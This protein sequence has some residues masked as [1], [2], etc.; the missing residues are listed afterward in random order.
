MTGR[1]QRSWGDFGGIKPQAALE[2]ECFR[3][4]ALGGV[5]DGRRPTS[6]RAG[7]L[8]SNALRLIGE[9]YAHVRSRGDRFTPGRAAMPQFANVCAYYPGQDA[10]AAAHSDEGA[11][12]MAGDMHRDVRDDR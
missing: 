9:V 6:R 3:T 1:F 8:D 7:A 2:Y 4:Q 5:D 12:L 11:M 10:D